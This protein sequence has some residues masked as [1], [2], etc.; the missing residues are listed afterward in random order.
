MSKNYFF[1]FS[2]AKNTVVLYKDEIINFN[3]VEINWKQEVLNARE[4]QINLI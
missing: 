1:S 2:Q 4:Y 3:N